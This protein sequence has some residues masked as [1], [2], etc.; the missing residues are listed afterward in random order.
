[1]TRQPP[2]RRPSACPTCKDPVPTDP[3]WPHRPFCSERCQQ[4]DLA[5]WLDESYVI[6]SPSWGPPPEEDDG[7]DGDDPS[8]DDGPLDLGPW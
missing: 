2:G 5:R 8:S 3:S 1:M 7:T 4:L 6:A